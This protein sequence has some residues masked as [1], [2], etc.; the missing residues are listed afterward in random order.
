MSNSEYLSESELF[1]MARTLAKDFTQ[2]QIASELEVTQSAV[3]QMLAGKPEML[4]LAIRWIESTLSIVE[5]EIEKDKAG[6][7]ER[8]YRV[9]RG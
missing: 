8:H 9:N 5:W 7:P 6:K 1:D 3:S 2:V 4:A